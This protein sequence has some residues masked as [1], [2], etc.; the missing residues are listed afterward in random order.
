MPEF[1][2]SSAHPIL[3]SGSIAASKPSPHRSSEER[4]ILKRCV[5]EV[6][7][8]EATIIACFGVSVDVFLT[9]LG[10]TIKIVVIVI[11][12]FI[13]IFRVD[14][15]WFA[16]RPCR[17]KRNQKPESNAHARILWISEIE[18][19]YR[20]HLRS[21]ARVAFLLPTLFFLILGISS[22]RRIVRFFFNQRID[23]GFHQP[24]FDVLR[25]LRSPKFGTQ[26]NS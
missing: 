3:A 22:V 17:D 1:S 19:L 26:T 4:T 21:P 13:Q 14:E 11:D 24:L 12:E 6:A 20:L 16:V 25:R 10:F 9:M 18:I 15:S 7:V 2:P 23:R 8:D 5:D